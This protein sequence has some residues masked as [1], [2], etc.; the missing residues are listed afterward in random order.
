MASS[1]LRLMRDFYASA[2]QLRIV[3][4]FNDAQR[5]RFGLD[6]SIEME[7]VNGML[8]TAN[9]YNGSGD[10][11]KAARLASISTKG[12]KAAPRYAFPAE[13]EWYSRSSKYGVCNEL[14][15]IGWTLDHTTVKAGSRREANMWRSFC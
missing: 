15:R 8:I 12:H 1:V 3:D 10:L 13:A 11:I 5:E 2:S 6:A 14:R 9:V 4:P 7:R